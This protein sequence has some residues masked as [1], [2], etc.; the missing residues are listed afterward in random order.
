[1]GSASS[2]PTQITIEQFKELAGDRY[3][4]QLFDE[5]ADE[6]R[7]ISKTTLFDLAQRTDVFISFCRLKRSESGAK[8]ESSDDLSGIHYEV[9]D[10][11]DRDR[12]IATRIHATFIEQGLITWFDP[13]EKKIET[14]IRNA[15]ENTSL[16]VVL[17]SQAY[18]DM[19]GHNNIKKNSLHLEFMHGLEVLGAKR[20][21]PVII[22]ENYSALYKLPEPLD[23]LKRN[24]NAVIMVDDGE[25]D[26]ASTKLIDTIFESITPLRVKNWRTLGAVYSAIAHEP[27]ESTRGMN[28]EV[29]TDEMYSYISSM[30][31][32]FMANVKLVKFNPGLGAAD[33]VIPFSREAAQSLAFDLLQFDIIS[34]AKLASALERFPL[35]LTEDLQR[36]SMEANAVSSAVRDADTTLL[37]MEER[38]RLRS[39]QLDSSMKRKDGK[40]WTSGNT[41]RLGERASISD[42]LVL[43]AILEDYRAA[44]VSLQSDVKAA[45]MRAF[46]AERLLAYLC[47]EM[48]DQ[49]GRTSLMAV[50]NSGRVDM[51]AKMIQLGADVLV[52]D[53]DGKNALMLAAAAGQ[54]DCVM[55]LL[56]AN[57]AINAQ[58]K[59]GDT[60][61]M[62]AAATGQFDIVK[63]L[64]HQGADPNIVNKDGFT[65]LTKAVADYGRADIVS[66]LLYKAAVVNIQTKN[67]WHP[68]LFAASLGHLESVRQL[69]EYDAPVNLTS[70]D[71]SSALLKAS[72][73]GHAEICRLLL[74]FNAKIDLK[75]DRGASALD[76][77]ENAEIREMLITAKETR[78]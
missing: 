9:L 8:S 51:V 2:I 56:D 14:Q 28:E 34:I 17:I 4:P 38:V 41:K 75:N 63:M 20:M 15:V 30:S 77:T 49:G 64:L 59:D 12:E 39:L 48:T 53:V 43:Q 13:N 32:W 42:P 60:A 61:L 57:A 26:Y 21:I 78:K 52:Q 68:L 69:L 74:E 3:N 27:R 25:F 73:N 54:T 40:T 33:E 35:L 16:M 11:L 6:N 66:L 37:E 44:V 1:M 55:T 76:V 10:E 71:G 50:A 29:I 5:V 46:E 23:V 31:E 24:D 70:S 47:S 19:L 67:G 62:M 22:D 58:T 72:E 18:V 36:D 45:Q 7:T 65:A